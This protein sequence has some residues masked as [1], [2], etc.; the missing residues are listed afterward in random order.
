MEQKSI[1]RFLLIVLLA[2]CLASFIMVSCILFDDSGEK[3]E[4]QDEP[5]DISEETTEE[6]AP[7]EEKT[8]EPVEEIRE[9]IPVKIWM[10]DIIPREIKDVTKAMPPHRTYY[11]FYF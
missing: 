4:T 8:D 2:L 7:E 1:L 3:Q 5:V 10:E 6:D 11:P 9:N